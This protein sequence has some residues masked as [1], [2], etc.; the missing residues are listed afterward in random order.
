[1]SGD[2]TDWSD[3]PET[4]RGRATEDEA[5][6]RK[7][8]W[9]KLKGGAARV[10]FAADAVAA[11]Y[12]AF[13]R[14]TPLRVRATL[15]GALAYFVLPIDAIP[16]LVPL[17]GLGDDAAMLFGALQLLSGHIKPRHR[18]AAE[19]ALRRAREG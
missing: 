8:F 9:R 10:P 7:G 6:V 16:D 14:E 4:E 5:R 15:L 19:D 18:E 12:A 2:S 11:Y 3:L 13:D 17:I 1:M